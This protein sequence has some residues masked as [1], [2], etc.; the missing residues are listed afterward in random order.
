MSQRGGGGV[1][2]HP[3]HPPQPTALTDSQ[4]GSPWKIVC[5]IQNTES[6]T[7]A[8]TISMPLCSELLEG[9]SHILRSDINETQCTS[10]TVLLTKVSLFCDDTVRKTGTGSIYVTA[11]HLI[12]Q[13]RFKMQ[14]KS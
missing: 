13:M 2:T 10:S 5:I 3:A 7:T 12:V 4:Q 11:R 8:V 1:R 6:A 9:E 14:L